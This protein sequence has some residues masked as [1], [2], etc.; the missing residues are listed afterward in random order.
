[1]NPTHKYQSD[2]SASWCDLLCLFLFGSNNEGPSASSSVSS[3]SSASSSV[4]VQRI[5]VN[6]LLAVKLHDPSKKLNFDD[7]IA[8]MSECMRRG[9]IQ[10]SQAANQELIILIGNTGAG[11]S[12][13]GNYLGGCTMIRKQASALGIPGLDGTFVVVKPLSQGGLLDEIMPIGHSKKSETFM[14]RLYTSREGYTLC[15]CPGFLDN[16]GI[17]INVANAVNMRNAFIRARGIKVV[18]LLNYST[19]LA[20]KARG[21]NEMIKICSDLFGSKEN[22]VRY[23]ESILLGI[24]QIPRAAAREEEE[25]EEPPRSLEDLK[26]WIAGADLKDHFANQTLRCLADRVF[27]YDPFDNPN[28]KFSGAWNRE[29]ILDNIRRLRPIPSPRTV[30]RTVITENDQFDLFQMCEQIKTR[31]QQ[32]F[33]RDDLAEHNFE[34][35]ARYQGS[36]N[37]LEMIEHHQVTKLVGETRGFII[38]QFNELIHNF[39]QRCLDTTS[40]LSP[41]SDAFLNQLKNGIRYFDPLIQARINIADLEKRLDLYKKRF[42]ATDLIN[43]LYEMERTFRNYCD[44][45]QFGSAEQL[46]GQIRQKWRQFDEQFGRTGITHSL[47]IGRLEVYYQKSKSIYEQDRIREQEYHKK[48]EL[49]K[50]KEEKIKQLS[51]Q[52]AKKEEEK[53][54]ELERQKE[55]ER[56]RELERKREAEKR[57]AERKREIEKREED[58]RQRELERKREA[59]KREAERK[60]EALRH[61]KA[62]R[63]R[64][65]EQRREARRLKDAAEEAEAKAQRL[66]D[67]RQR[68]LEE[69]ERQDK[70]ERKRLAEEKR[71][72]DQAEEARAAVSLQTRLFGGPGSV[73]PQM[74]NYGPQWF[75]QGPNG[76]AFPVIR[77]KLGGYVVQTPSGNVYTDDD[78]AVRM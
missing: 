64:E 36:L 19:L 73:F 30:F 62:E 59:E 50:K 45:K 77:E 16:R 66:E 47:D 25:E 12:T 31:I 56:Q 5:N 74:T 32:L 41:E 7:S 6:D 70:I 67:E 49:Q 48:I 42:L 9:E 37:Q 39:E 10:A 4:P 52:T 20:D 54:R 58:E 1:M 71:A 26:N 40:N 44:H 28:L 76:R 55:D 3:P 38:S 17:E 46:L 43:S 24:T 18:M 69:K 78:G 21:L 22:L 61:R 13:F 60:R 51:I 75:Y 34:R 27:I 33:P 11:K 63:E 53:K 15:D 65:A 29:T 8:L 14:P 23:R 68:R 57:E 72:N 35:V 2:T